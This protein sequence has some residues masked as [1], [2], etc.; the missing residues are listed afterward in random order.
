MW[1]FVKQ[2]LLVAGV[3]VAQG[4]D[5]QIFDDLNDAGRRWT[6]TIEAGNQNIEV[7]VGRG[8]CVIMSP[9]QSQLIATSIGGTV[10]AYDPFSG[11]R[12]WGYDAPQ[13]GITRSH[14]CVAFPPKADMPYMVYAVVDN[15]N[16]VT[17]TT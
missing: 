5:A 15:E 8:N 7:G 17:P 9:D 11:D 4:T 10:S 2:S 6:A 3:L 1:S 14:S 13:N 16:S 12:L